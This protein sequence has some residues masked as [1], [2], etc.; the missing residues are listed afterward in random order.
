MSAWTVAI[1]VDTHRDTHTA[2]AL[3][4][5]GRVLGVLELSAD[6]EGYARLL[7]WS[8]SL[9]RPAFALEGSGSY[10]LGL[11]RF[12]SEAGG[13]VYEVER[14]TRRDRRRGKS[15]RRDAELAAHRLVRGEG[16]AHLR[17]FGERERL[18]ALLAERRS[19]R[20]AYVAALNQ[21]HAL[22]IA[23]P[24][25]L[26]D[27]LE[28]LQG[29]RLARAAIRLRSREATIIRRL[30]GRALRLAAETA[31]IDRELEQSLRTLAPEL[32]NEPGV[33][34]VCAAQLLVSAGEP[35]RMRS[36]AAFAALAGVSP[37]E[38]SSGRIHRHR[39]NRG[40]DRQLNAALHRIALQRSR[41]HPETIGYT[42]RLLARGKSKREALRCVKR[43][44]AR[45]FYRKL[46]ELPPP[47]P[48]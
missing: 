11:A 16:L 13:E 8:R 3:D 17:G 15:D 7:G 24:P 30:A 37:V 29:E 21:L 46:I 41:I 9:G 2:V 18:R 42:E 35:A 33:G 43:A 12:L 1:G 47:T 19:G 26:R 31:L 4:R 36:E 23:A 6:A 22:V 5:L 44:L 28:Q 39:L 40:G 32:L 25:S 27:R 48:N 38:A 45:H 14:P 34:P 10:G 20:Q